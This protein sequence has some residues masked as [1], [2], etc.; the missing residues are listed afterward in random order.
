MKS[1]SNYFPQRR[2]QGF[3]LIEIMVVVAIIAILSSII[4]PLY[5]EQTRKSQ[6]SE[7]IAL[8]TMLRLEMERC[9]SNNN[10]VYSIICPNLATAFVLPVISAKYDPSGA[11]GNYYNTAIVLIPDGSGYTINI[12]DPIG[13]DL[14]CT[15]F[16]LDNFGTKGFTQAAGQQSSVARCWGGS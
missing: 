4:W 1:H 13:K 9:A 5:L 10:G 11:R 8:A 7:A 2:T 14:D 15:S 12:T 16:T 6:R 3:S